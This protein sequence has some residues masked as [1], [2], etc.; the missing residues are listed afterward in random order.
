MSIMEPF[1]VT[2]PACAAV[3]EMQACYSV[4]ADRRPDLREAIL[5]GSF[6]TGTCPTCGETFRLDPAFNYLDMERGQ[7]ISAQPLD[8]LADWSARE[9]EAS[10]T[11][12]LA[13]GDGAP[14]SAR[15]VGDALSAR[16]VFGWAALREK[17]VAAQSSIDDATL[18][19]A[20][21]VLMAGGFGGNAGPGRELRLLDATGEDLVIAWIDAK[22]EA[23]VET[24][25]APRSLLDDIN[26]AAEDW[27][28]TRSALTTGPFL[29]VGRLYLG[30]AVAA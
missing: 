8:D 19:T 9:A 23:E 4:N 17:I 16:L 7:W 11:F 29:D 20:K 14:A 21:L 10:E 5:D 27:A 6:Q 30:R 1:S 13:Y 2:C 3:F 24:F 22:T 12:R 18:E 26:T 25:T 28:P 15:I